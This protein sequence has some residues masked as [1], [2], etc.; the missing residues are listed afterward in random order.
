MARRGDDDHDDDPAFA[1]Q[2]GQCAR[3]AAILRWRSCVARGV[4][5][6]HCIGKRGSMF[7]LGHCTQ[8]TVG[9]QGKREEA[10]E[11]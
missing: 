9:G 1:W 11:G 10:D 3:R 5:I 7:N 8:Y 2:S 4:A 6:P